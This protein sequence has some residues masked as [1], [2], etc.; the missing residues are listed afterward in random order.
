[1]VHGFLIHTLRCRPGEEAGHSRV[2][3]S[4]VFSPEGLEDARCQERDKERLCR[5]EQL[6]VVARQV[7]SACKLHQQASGKPHSEHLIQLPDEPV[8]L[9]DAPSGV[10]RLPPGDPFSEDKTV[11]WL[12]VQCLAFALVC[13]PHENLMLAESTLRL[14]AKVLLDRL[15]LLSSGS[16]ILLKADRTEAVLHRF[17]PHGQLLFLNE[18]FVVALEKEASASLCK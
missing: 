12:G 18:Q 11:L 16:D 4:R 3:Y 6:L 13:D 2:L 7:E 14:L 8:S 5:K 17:L 1:M 9:Q 10:F 15:K